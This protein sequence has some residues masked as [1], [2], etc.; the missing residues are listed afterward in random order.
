M[1]KQSK[2]T[3]ATKTERYEVSAPETAAF[4]TSNLEAAQKI[5]TKMKTELRA[6]IYFVDHKEKIHW[7]YQILPNQ[8]NYR[9]FQKNYVAPV[10]EEVVTVA[11]EDLV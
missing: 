4:L 8:K 3:P 5:A 9:V 2:A 10:K 6:T 11:P 7:V 1:K